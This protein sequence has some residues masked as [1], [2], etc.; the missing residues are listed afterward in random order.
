MS[1]P[2][3]RPRVT[4]VSTG[5]PSS[6]TTQTFPACTDPWTAVMGRVSTSVAVPAWTATSAAIP[7]KTGVPGGTTHRAVVPVPLPPPAAGSA[8]GSAPPPAPA[9]AAGAPRVS[10]VQVNG[11]GPPWTVTSAVAGADSSR[12]WSTMLWRSAAISSA[13]ATAASR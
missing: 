11:A 6:P 8:V 5:V 3:V 13:R 9:G 4:G 10:P 7:A 12:N 1:S 2:S